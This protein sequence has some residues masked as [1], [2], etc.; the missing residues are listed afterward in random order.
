MS[1]KMNLKPFYQTIGYMVAVHVLCLLAMTLCR[2]ILVLSNTPVE[3]IDWSLLLTAMVIGVKFDNLI[4][5]FMGA[6]PIAFLTIW[7]ICLMDKPF[8]GEWM[9]KAITGVEWY[10]SVVY[11]VL[12]FVGVADAR[13]YMFFENHLNISVTE[14]FGF[15]GDTA[16]MVFGDKL[17]LVFLAIAVAL[18][19]AYIGALKAIGNRYKKTL[20]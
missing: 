11:A 14:W 15:V 6:A 9:K 20:L 3:G 18:I 19:L 8:Y 16:G 13:Y 7:S 1:G 10:M 2:V 17:N 5:C 4:A 12:L